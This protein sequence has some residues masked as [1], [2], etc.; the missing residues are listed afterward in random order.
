M[1]NYTNTSRNILSLLLAACSLPASASAQYDLS[2]HSI[3][4]GG[5]MF[6]TGGDYRLGG[7]IGQADAGASLSGDSFSLIG[8]FWP[9]A[10]SDPC[11]LLG[12]ID[13]DHDTDL[14]DLAFLLASFGASAGDPTFNP[15]A[16]ID[17]NGTVTLQDLAFL[18]SNF[19]A[20]CR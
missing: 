2:W 6:S 16:D 10:D 14:Q 12:D 19:G 8:G 18:L 3:D 11:D 20:T 1:T 15:A 7:T 5:A 4:N 17:L 13:N 9:G